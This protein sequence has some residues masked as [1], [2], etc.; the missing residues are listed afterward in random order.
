LKSS[1]PNTIRQASAD[2]AGVIHALICSLAESLGDRDRMSATVSDIR[3]A[4]SGTEP[5][6]YAF[7]A[8]RDAEVLGGA[9]FF[10]TF[11]TWRG[12]RGVYLQDIY[13]SPAWRGNGGG[14]KLLARVVSWAAEHGADHLRLSVDSDNQEAQAFYQK[15]GMSYC[16]KE[17]IYQIEDSAFEALRVI[18]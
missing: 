5:A 15:A 12:T 6:L 11:S 18:S 10:L 7:I 4:L 2:D 16:N 17:M 14:K 8:E 1:E 13:V 3:T 9:T